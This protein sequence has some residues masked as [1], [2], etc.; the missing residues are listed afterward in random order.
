MEAVI[1]IGLQG[2]GKSTFYKERFATTHIHISLDVLKTRNQEK[3]TL[4]S[5]ITARQKVVIDNTNATVRERAEYISVAKG[6]GYKVLGYY[7][8]CTVQD[9][10]KRNQLR[11]GKARIPPAGLF[12]TRKRLQIPSKTEGFED[13]Y[14]VHADQREGFKVAPFPES[15]EPLAFRR[16]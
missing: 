4:Q 7:F 12:A 6:A 13:L 9:C 2:S 16:G 15:F 11:A 3:A 14:I 8:D 5:A 1:L 10:L